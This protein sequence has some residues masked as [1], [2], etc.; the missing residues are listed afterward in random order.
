MTVRDL[1]PSRICPFCAVRG[2]NMLHEPSHACAICPSGHQ[3]PG[4][5]SQ[6]G[7]GGFRDS[8]SAFGSGVHARHGCLEAQVSSGNFLGP[9]SLLEEE[10]L[11]AVGRSLTW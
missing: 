7:K 11:V 4:V 9:T 1:S 6:V 2:M 3:I 8:N 10:D 5:T